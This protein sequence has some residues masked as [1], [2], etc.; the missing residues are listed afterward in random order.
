M[1]QISSEHPFEQYPLWTALVTP[2]DQQGKVDFVSLGKIAHQQ[3]SA[4]NAILL[5]GSTGEGLALIQ[6]EQRTIVEYVCGLSLNV[7]IMVAV[8]G[9]QLIEQLQWIEQ[10]NQLPVDAYLLG[11]PLYAKP[12]EEGQKL[13]FEALLDRAKFPCML[14]NVPSRSGLSLSTSALASLQHHPKCWALKEASGDVAQFKEYQKAC[15]DIALYSGEDALLPKLVEEGAKGLV[16][17]AANVWPIQTR[18]YVQQC[19]TGETTGLFPVWK[20]AV[21]SLFAVSNPIPAKILMAKNNDIANAT[22]RPPLTNKELSNH[23]SLEHADQ[24]ITHWHQQYSSRQISQQNVLK[25][26]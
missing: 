20:N 11:S 13:W 18:A 12:G 19:L 8:G 3:N 15:P 21:D 14:Y 17:V 16:S 7:P 26:A 24:Q 6:E 2:F 10:C 25:T 23:Q 5:L 4:G 22:L 9:F 1:N